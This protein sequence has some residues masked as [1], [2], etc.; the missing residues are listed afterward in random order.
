M[1][2]IDYVMAV[3][4]MHKAEKKDDMPTTGG[5]KGSGLLGSSG[6]LGSSTVSGMSMLQSQANQQMSVLAAP[7]TGPTTLSAPPHQTQ[8]DVSYCRCGEWLYSHHDELQ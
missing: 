3:I 4:G 7:Y 1:R 2:L 5:T 6:Q 8:L